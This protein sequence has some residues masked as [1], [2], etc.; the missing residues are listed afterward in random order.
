[1]SLS[2][3]LAGLALQQ[4]PMPPGTYTFTTNARTASGPVCTEQWELR[5][6]GTMTVRSGQEVLEK[7]Y[8]FERDGDGDR[9]VVNITATNAKPDCQGD[10]TRKPNKGDRSIYLLVSNDGSVAVCIPPRHAE[11]GTPVHDQCY[12]RLTR[13]P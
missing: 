12:A 10:V 5:A 7:R 6:D 1:M 9:I 4:A 11:D 3:L 2:L 13:T 8:R